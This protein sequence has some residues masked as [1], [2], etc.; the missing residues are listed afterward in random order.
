[1]TKSPETVF[2]TTK[3]LITTFAVTVTIRAQPINYLSSEE[4]AGFIIVSTSITAIK[5][6]TSLK[7]STFR[8]SYFVKGLTLTR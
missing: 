4:I 8:C 5:I 2:D 1:M 3:R 6:Q 7:S